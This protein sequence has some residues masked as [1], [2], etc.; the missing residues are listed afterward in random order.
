MDSVA[1]SVSH[2]A[3]SEEK[4]PS[5]PNPLL[6]CFQDAVNLHEQMLTPAPIRGVGDL[7]T[8]GIHRLPLSEDDGWTFATSSDTANH[9]F[10]IDSSIC[11]GDISVFID[12]YIY[13]GPRA[14]RVPISGGA[15]SSIGLMSLADGFHFCSATWPIV[16]TD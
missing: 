3:E 11:I 6:C 15:S 9:C 7:N 16:P 2:F 1:H 8:A 14:S 4:M 13:V 12:I 5:S 10:Q